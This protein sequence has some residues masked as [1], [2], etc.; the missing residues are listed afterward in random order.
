MT[1]DIR[2]ELAAI[3]HPALRVTSLQGQEA[4][5]QP[6]RFEID[7]CTS[8]PALPLDAII[9]HGATLDIGDRRVTGIVAEIE[10]GEA[11]S[12]G[13]CYR[14]VLAPRLWLLSLATRSRVFRDMSLPQIATAVAAAA[15]IDVS[16]RLS[17]PYAVDRFVVQYRESDLSFMSRLLES[18][19]ISYHLSGDTLVLSDHNGA[20]C[21][22]IGAS[23]NDGPVRVASLTC[24][25]RMTPRALLLH[26]ADPD[27]T[28]PLEA[29][30]T[31]DDGGFGTQIDD[32]VR[33]LTPEHGR[34]VALRH[35]EALRAGATRYNGESDRALGAG[36]RLTLEGHF[37][38]DF[39]RSYIVVST[40]C[41]TKGDVLCSRFEALD[42]D[43]VYRPTRTTPQPRVGGVIH[44]SIDADVDERGRYS[45]ALPFDIEGHAGP[46][47]RPV[48]LI[49][50]DEGARFTLRK[51]TPV[52]LDFL[53]GDPSRPL[54]AGAV[55]NARRSERN[56]NVIGTPQGAII[57]MSGSFARPP[58][59]ERRQ[60]NGAL[61]ELRALT[62]TVT[63]LASAEYGEE[64]S[65]AT[66]W[67]RFAVP[68]GDGKWS[69]LRYG[70]STSTKVTST[71]ETASGFSETANVDGPFNSKYF[72]SSGEATSGSGNE[73]TW[74]GLNDSPFNANVD[75]KSP[76][77]SS[78][79][80]HGSSAGVFDYTDGNRCTVT[81]G[82]HQSV[83][84]GHR[85]DVILGDYRLVIPNRTNGVYDADTYWMRFRKEAGNWR[86]TER[87]HV[88]S[89]AVTWGDTESLFMGFNLDGFFGSKIGVTIGAQVDAFIG[90][91]LEL[92]AGITAKFD[93]GHSFEY[94]YG[95]QF[96][97]STKHEVEA[98]DRITLRIPGPAEEIKG[99]AFQKGC[100]AVMTV[101]SGGLIAAS[102]VTST[103]AEPLG[104]AKWAVGITLTGVSTL[105]FIGALASFYMLKDRKAQA[106]EPSIE[107]TPDYIKLTIGKAKIRLQEDHIALCVGTTQLDVKEDYIALFAPET[108]IVEGDFI[109]TDGKFDVKKGPGTI[110][111]KSIEVK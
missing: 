2:F 85:T 83:T 100:A 103:Q 86:K 80:T 108:D 59:G 63:D 96:S 64:S 50:P 36:Q 23:M 67:I 68:H 14:A 87:S 12:D 39:N 10:Q 24:T 76:G 101:V 65:G 43:T 6:F 3:G 95:K 25:R 17:R 99:A 48:A 107:L 7:I 28:E 40:R 11:C 84:Q 20:F 104:E 74:A 97:N 72:N 29:R 54:I 1:P 26:D 73:F 15:G 30:A 88:S 9:G 105:A 19:G 22:A 49:S 52:V 89:D 69:Y 92:G 38:S 70:E 102:T 111:N 18:E 61:S 79:F 41:E 94:S 51:G 42:A 66:D 62:S 58:E 60:A 56:T 46:R 53:D 31:V 44:A 91:K 47:S 16:L 98:K 4:L 109:V 33:L 5:S 77:S 90:Y 13:F 27:V 55:P 75:D 93:L 57:E 45:V 35:A 34:E 82:D 71:D 37:R 21:D 110:A 78:Y 81:R 32:A 106:T 8:E